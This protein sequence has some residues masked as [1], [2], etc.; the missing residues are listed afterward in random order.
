MAWNSE[1]DRAVLD[2]NGK[3]LEFATL[4]LCAIGLVMVYAATSPF[5]DKS[6]LG[7]VEDTIPTFISQ[8]LKLA[9][10]VVAF[11]LGR[12]VSLDLVKRNSGKLL[13]FAVFVLAMVPFF[14]ITLNSSNRWLR[15]GGITFQP[16]EMVKLAVIAWT[17]SRLATIG[18]RIRDLRELVTLF[19]VGVGPALV[20]LFLQPDFGSSV[21]LLGVALVLA[22]IA[23]ARFR[24]YGG[25]M[26]GGFAALY[27]LAIAFYP[28]V[29]SRFQKHADPQPSDQV[30]QALLSFGAGGFA[31]VDGGVGAGS[32][33]LGFVPM[34]QSD[35]IMSAIGE[36]TGFVGSSIVIALF[37]M[38]T[39]AGARIALLQRDR[40]RFLLACGLV[41]NVAVQAMI[42][43]VV[44]TA[45]GPTKGIALPFISSGGSAVMFS[46]FGVGLLI[47]L[48]RRT[49]VEAAA[50]DRYAGDADTETDPGETQIPQRR[51]QPALV[52][53]REK[54]V[55]QHG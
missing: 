18:D 41:I 48:A 1:N 33:K 17:A 31:G 43:F 30:Y 21:F 42:N 29:V 55:V 9:L 15:F 24:H 32:G 16:V 8:S 7:G 47:N 44:V 2:Q 27:L 51:A 40:F 46:L 28:H 5:W 26:I 19:A 4:A 11:L 6:R 38:F 12:F 54:M 20:L 10:G 39:Y 52:G 34:V 23:G 25:G 36:E 50:G 3:R 14:G 22:I 35:F 37:V 49:P 53:A 45:L 13:I